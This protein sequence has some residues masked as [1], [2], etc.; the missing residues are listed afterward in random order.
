MFR[1]NPSISRLLNDARLFYQC[2]ATKFEVWSLRLD[3]LQQPVTMH[4]RLIPDR[5]LRQSS[6]FSFIDRTTNPHGI[7]YKKCLKTC[8]PR[9]L[10]HGLVVGNP[11]ALL[12]QWQQGHNI[13]RILSTGTT[14]WCNEM[15]E[16]NC[17]LNMTMYSHRYST[18]WL[19]VAA[20]KS[21]TPSSCSLSSISSSS[22]SARAG[23][24][25]HRRRAAALLS[26][27]SSSSH[28]LCSNS[29]TASV[30]SVKYQFPVNHFVPE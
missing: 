25:R 28:M 13:Y 27:S 26:W 24:L 17:E 30:S 6:Q 14:L 11:I 12:H 23:F 7:D 20:D 18:T 16:L 3:L 2:H 1:F 19:V 9:T 15:S 10:V 5:S 22:C 21:A 29:L 8:H 4:Y